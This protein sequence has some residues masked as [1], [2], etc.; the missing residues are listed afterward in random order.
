MKKKIIIVSVL[1]LF[2]LSGI[3]Y[4]AFIKG[5]YVEVTNLTQSKVSEIQISC[6]GFS[7]KIDVEPS[8]TKIIKL[9]F[10]NSGDNSLSITYLL[11]GQTKKQQFGYFEGYP[12]EGTFK[13]IYTE[14]GLELV[15][16]NITL[17]L[18]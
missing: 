16:E 3:I 7:K 11:N 5:I 4:F 14:N 1:S 6:R 9:N 8:E 18:L 15:N 2:A 10:S 17:N 12:Y 13:F